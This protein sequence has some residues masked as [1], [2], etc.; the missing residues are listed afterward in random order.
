M[1]EWDNA[2]I[3]ENRLKIDAT[4]NRQGGNSLFSWQPR[5]E[6]Y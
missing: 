4:G 2:R 1:R 5:K 3:R 6:N